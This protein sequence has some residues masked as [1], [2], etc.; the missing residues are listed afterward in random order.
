MHYYRTILLLHVHLYTDLTL[1]SYVSLERMYMSFN[2]LTVLR[3]ISL[4]LLNCFHLLPKSD[5]TARFLA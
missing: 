5:Y 1:L 3:S 4:C 2:S